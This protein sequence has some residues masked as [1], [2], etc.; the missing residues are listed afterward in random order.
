MTFEHSAPKASPEGTGLIHEVLVLV[1]GDQE[2]GV[3]QIAVPAAAVREVARVD[4]ITAYPG[5]PSDVPGVTA[6]RGQIVPVLDLTRDLTRGIAG[7]RAVV[8]LALG[9]RALALAGA[10]PVRVASAEDVS[11]RS[12]G[13]RAHVRLWS[14]R[15]L[16]VAGAVRLH[17]AARPDAADGRVLPL[18]DAAALID[19]VVD[20]S[21]GEN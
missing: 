11:H 18:L 3:V 8:L 17:D 2:P 21:D 15:L 5:A 7:A 6:V 14:G 12:P 20:A 4:R 9:T 1:L 10:T 19:D 16:P 13:A